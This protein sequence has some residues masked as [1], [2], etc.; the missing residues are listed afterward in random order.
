MSVVAEARSNNKVLL[1]I[2][3]DESNLFIRM[4]NAL[5]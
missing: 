3:L 4:W 1:R 2:C 5:A